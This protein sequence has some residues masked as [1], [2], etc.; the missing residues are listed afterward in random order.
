MTQTTGEKSS[1]CFSRKKLLACNNI[2]GLVGWS[3]VKDNFFL[4]LIF[5]VYKPPLILR[6]QHKEV[7][8]DVG[9]NYCLSSSFNK[10]TTKTMEHFMKL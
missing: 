3:A 7:V 8:G 6:V 4:V 2:Y 5:W 9:P 1:G 10:I